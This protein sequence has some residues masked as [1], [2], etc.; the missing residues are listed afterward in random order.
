MVNKVLIVDDDPRNLLAMTALLEEQRYHVLEA[1]NGEAAL[2]TLSTRPDICCVLLDLMMPGIDG[3][4][5]AHQIRHRL[6][7]SS[8]PIVAVTAKTMPEDEQRCREVGCS[9]FVTK[10]VDTDE[11]LGIVKRLVRPAGSSWSC[12]R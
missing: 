5:V 12:Y 8:L 6:R 9:V 3:F 10:P 7:L 11:L 1:S 2:N 4:E